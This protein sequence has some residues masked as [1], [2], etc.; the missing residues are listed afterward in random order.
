MTGLHVSNTFAFHLSEPREKVAPL[1]GAHKERG[2]AEGWN[3]QFLYPQPPEDIQGSV[4]QVAKSEGESTWITTIF[5]VERGHVQHVYFIPNVMAVLI[6]IH[7]SPVNGS[8]TDVEVRYER[9]ALSAK[10]N[11]HIRDSG[12][13]DAASADEWRAA[14]EKYFQRNV[15]R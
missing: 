6:N 8:G 4:F 13:Q 11:D 9:T 7:L 5:D 15:T 14:I 1:F 10:M 2:W 3:P 12:E